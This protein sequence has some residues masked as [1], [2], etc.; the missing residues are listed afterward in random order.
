MK[1]GE[2]REE[3]VHVKERE[4]LAFKRLFQF[5]KKVIKKSLWKEENQKIER[6]C[7][8]RGS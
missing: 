1:S 4:K 8:C 3:E 6:K 5:P 2:K 7:L